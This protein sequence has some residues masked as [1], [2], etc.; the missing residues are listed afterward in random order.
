MDI[1]TLKEFEVDTQGIV[2]GFEVKWK[3]ESFTQKLLG[4]ILFFNPTYMT[5]YITTFYP[6][7]YFPSKERYEKNPMNSLRILAHER[8]HL[9]DSSHQG[10]W[11]KTSYL[12]PQA[13]FVPF[14]LAS[15]GFFIGG[16]NI[17]ALILLALGLTSLIP[18]PS[19]WR[20]HWEQRGYAMTLA[21]A[22]WLLGSIPISLKNSV[23]ERFLDWTYFRMS[24]SPAAIDDWMKEVISSIEGGTILN[25]ESYASVHRFLLGKDLVQQ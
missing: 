9:I 8:V 7:V 3:N 13:L 2:P 22:Y 18:W 4:W 15:V 11:F 10:L 20:V 6:L 17:V 1:T 25:D 16:L 12:L 23:R 24:W 5:E 14:I 19:P 21:T